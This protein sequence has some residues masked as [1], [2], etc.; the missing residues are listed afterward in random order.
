MKPI[1]LS[2]ALAVLAVPG[3]ASIP[4]GRGEISASVTA[5]VTHDSNVFGTPDAT[6]DWSGLLIPR[7]KYARKA[8]R[9][10]AEVDAGISIIRNREQTQLDAENLDGSVTLRIL[11]ADARKYSG[12]FSAV[13]RESSDLNSDLNARINTKSTV[14][15]AESS[16]ITGP[17]TRAALSGSY[18]DY[19][20]S[21]GSDQQV[22]T[23]EALY[24]YQDF[25]YG[26]F[27]RLTGTYHQLSSS[28]ENVLGVPL[29][30]T[31]YMAAAGLGRKL[32]HDTFQ[33][34]ISYGHR[35]LIRSEAETVAGDRRQNGYVF[36]ATLEGPFLSK[37]SFPKITSLISLSYQD[38]AVPGIYDAGTRELTGQLSLVWKARDNTSFNFAVIRSQRLAAN[39]LA[40]VT[41]I[42]RLGLEQVLRY[43]LTGTLSASYDW[44]SFRSVSR[45]DK[46]ATLSAGLRY[47]F[48]RVWAASFSSNFTS[49]TSTIPAAGYDRLVTSLSVTRE[50]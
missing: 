16:L 4:V 29:E 23:T 13:Y 17:R 6:A 38:A 43:N 39:D 36:G 37:R 30:R 28:G 45:Q 7:L 25:F 46:T 21:A 9:I 48:A 44:S 5:A 40:V 34:F 12:L 18:S 33:G 1:I 27:L 15:T 20:R 3:W 24:D 19:R 2:A 42:V 22:L 31:S 32:Y 50:F 35:I 11:A 10:E 41:T 8:G 47:K 14:L 49:I 26:N